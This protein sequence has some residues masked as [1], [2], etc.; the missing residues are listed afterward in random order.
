MPNPSLCSTHR[1]GSKYLQAGFIRLQQLAHHFKKTFHKQ[2][3]ALTVAG[4]Q[5]LVQS[6]HG[7][8]HVPKQEIHQTTYQPGQAFPAKVWV[9]VQISAGQ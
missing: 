7:Y 6:F 5:Q 9:L 2:V 1:V 8:A 4:H 3:D